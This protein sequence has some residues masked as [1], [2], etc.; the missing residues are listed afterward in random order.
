[1]DETE[2]TASNF[3][4]R[5]RLEIICILERGEKCHSYKIIGKRNYFTLITKFPAKNGEL[6]QLKY[7]ASGRQTVSHQGKKEVS[8]EEK[9][10][11]KSGSI[12]GTNLQLVLLTNIRIRKLKIRPM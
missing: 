10:P 2:F 4:L 11:N 6:T 12:E 8:N 9:L 3:M 1:M 5:D 7:N